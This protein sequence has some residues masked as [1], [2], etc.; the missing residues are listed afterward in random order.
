MDLLTPRGDPLLA[1]WQYGL[2]RAAV[3]TSDLKGRWG[4]EWVRWGDFSRFAAQTVGWLLPSPQVEGLDARVSLTEEGAVIQL[5]AQDGSG[6]PLN[7]LSVQA[8]LIAPDLTTSEITLSQV[9]PGQYLAASRADQPGTYLVWLAASK[10]EQPLGQMTLGMVVPY[11]P[12]Y[13]AGGINR[14][15]LDELARVTGGGPLKAPI[16]AFL[17]N[18]PSSDTAREIG[19]TLLLIAALLFPIDVAIRRVMFSRRD[20]QTARAWVIERLPWQRAAST[21]GEP[22]VLGQLFNARE[23]AR[24]KTTARGEA[25]N[26]P[27]PARPAAGSSQPPPVEGSPPAAP[28]S[29]PAPPGESPPVDSFSRLREAK[30]RARK[31]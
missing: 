25:A 31:Q 4:T 5:N 21:R 10:N 11:S 28:P 6:R 26:L 15:L 7:D 29:S 1:S 14:G 24:R 30:R 23:R 13:R 20:M 3:W 19:R 9:G 2:G 8:R 27:Q 17:H 12:E 16:E 22:P 18:L